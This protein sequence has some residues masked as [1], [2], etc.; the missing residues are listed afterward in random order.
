MDAIM[1]KT[2]DGMPAIINRKD[3][4]ESSEETLELKSAEGDGAAEDLKEDE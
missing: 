3:E 2:V 4:G 1:S